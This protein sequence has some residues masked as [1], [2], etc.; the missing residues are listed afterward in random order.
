MAEAFGNLSGQEALDQVA[1][2][3]LPQP[4]IQEFARL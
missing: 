2:D 1:S 4:G 3:V